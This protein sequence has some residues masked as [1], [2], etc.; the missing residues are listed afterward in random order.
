MLLPLSEAYRYLEEPD[1][2]PLETFVTSNHQVLREIDYFRRLYNLMPEMIVSYDRHALH[3]VDD[4]ELR[5]TFDFDLRC[6]NEELK[7]EQGPYGENF[8]DKN[9]VVLEV[10][11]N[12]SVPLWL[13]RILQGVDCEQRSAS[14]FCTSSELLKEVGLPHGVEKEPISIGG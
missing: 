3:G 13:T 12:D 10:K 5:I 9:L 1:V 6:R 7:L 11:V 14:K 8:I 2:Y 4:P